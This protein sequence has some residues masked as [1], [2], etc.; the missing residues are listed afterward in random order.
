MKNN[1]GYCFHFCVCV[2]VF[3]HLGH[4]PIEKLSVWI[5]KASA[6]DPEDQHQDRQANSAHLHH[7]L[8]HNNTD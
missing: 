7:R 5:Q 4:V 3:S 8:R 6:A 2:C 1:S